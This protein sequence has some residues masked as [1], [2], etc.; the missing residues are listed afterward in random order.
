MKRY[1][2]VFCVLFFGSIVSAATY[3]GHVL[4]TDYETKLSITMRTGQ[5]AQVNLNAQ[6]SYL[7]KDGQSISKYDIKKDDKVEVTTD[8]GNDATVVQ[9]VN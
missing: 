3:S 9:E 8:A 4:S 6:T 2:V 7:D 1:I 5:E